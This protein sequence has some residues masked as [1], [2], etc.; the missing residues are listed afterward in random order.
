ML[1]GE[2]RMKQNCIYIFRV[3][4]N[5]VKDEFV[6][7][8]Q[9]GFYGAAEELRLWKS[10]L[11]LQGMPGQGLEDSQTKLSSLHHPGVSW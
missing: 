9:E 2:V 4:E 11:L 3:S 8:L 1:T 5:K 7:F 6:Q 10:F